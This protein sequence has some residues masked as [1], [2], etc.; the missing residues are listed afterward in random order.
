[1][2]PIFL[3]GFMGSGKSKLG[4]KLASK[5]ACAVVDTD[6]LIEEQEGMSVKEIFDTKG[7][8]YFRSLEKQLI[9]QLNSNEQLIVAT[10]GGLPCYNNLMEELNQLGTTVYL[11]MNARELFSR[12]QTEENRAKRP[13][14][15][16]KTDEE[17]L[18]YIDEKLKE[19]ESIYLKSTIIFQPTKSTISDL[20]QL[21]LHHERNS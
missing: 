18:D 1:M 3:V 7:E 13:L 2:K 12:L 16:N 8:D 15:L 9:T 4:K 11:Q 10:G 21:I 6:S 17:L 20:I 5:L 14:L 19:R